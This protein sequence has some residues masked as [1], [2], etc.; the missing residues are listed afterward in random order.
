MTD[1]QLLERQVAR[2]FGVDLADVRAIAERERPAREGA[3]AALAELRRRWEATA[4]VYAD[5]SGLATGG[6]A[7]IG[8]V[9]VRR[10]EV[11]EGS[12]ELRAATNQQAE[13][14]AAA[15]ALDQ[16]PDGCEVI[17][18][19]DS[20]Y[21]VKGWNE[22]RPAWQARGWRTAAGRQVANPRHWA[23]LAEAVG[24]HR[25]VEFRWVRGHDGCAGNECADAL[26]RAARERAGAAV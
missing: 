13:L 16:L 14:L 22:W 24:R 9:A 12:L 2:A 23:R 20:E 26:A 17:L 18:Y 11:S 15:Y 7:G 21:V 4:I 5:G 6:P 1:R 19:S 25:A 8:Y 3:D 10:G